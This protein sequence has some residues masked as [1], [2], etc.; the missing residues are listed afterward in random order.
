[1]GIEQCDRDLA[2]EKDRAEMVGFGIKQRNKSLKIER[3][4]K[5]QSVEI[6]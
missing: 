1:M 6:G 5:G 2:V 4:A 3:R